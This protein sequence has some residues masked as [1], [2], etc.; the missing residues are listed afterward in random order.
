M[1]NVGEVLKIANEYD[2][3]TFDVFD[4]LIIRDVQKPADIFTLAYGKIGRYF[5]VGAEM[6]ARMKSRNGATI[7][8]PKYMKIHYYHNFGAM[9]VILIFLGSITF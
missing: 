8:M 4:T 9:G 3:I 1:I 7:L 2:V 6:L 5:R